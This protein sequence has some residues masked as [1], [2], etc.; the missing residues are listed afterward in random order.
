MCVL[1]TVDLNLNLKKNSILGELDYLN[2]FIGLAKS[3]INYKKV[4]KLLTDIQNDIFV[5]QANIA[6]PK[7][8]DYLPNSIAFDRIISLQKDTYY[9][10]RSLAKI[11]H[12]IVPDGT[13]GACY[14][15]CVRTISRQVERRF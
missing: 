5:I 4:R 12:F 1:K 7:N 14:L 13:T 8:V 2:S 3:F 6:S 9:I 15:H 11:N 10:E